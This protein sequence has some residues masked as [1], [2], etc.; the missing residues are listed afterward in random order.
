MP[1]GV[2]N[3][4]KKYLIMEFHF[5]PVQGHTDAPYRMMHSRHYGADQTYYT[6]F[7]RV[8]G[9]GI[10]RQDLKSLDHDFTDGIELIPQ[11][12]FRDAQELNILVNA[13]KEQG[14][15]RIDLNMGCPFPLQTARGRGAATI[16]NKELAL[17]VAE[18]VNNN[19]EISFSVKTRLGLND[20]DEWKQLLPVLNT[21]KLRHIT[22]HPR[23]AR[24]QYT[25][26]PNLEKFKEFLT[27]STNPVIYNGDILTPA[28]ADK[29]MSE[30]PDIKGIMIGRGALARPSIFSEI[31]SKEEWD[32]EKRLKKL[33]IFHRDLL[34]YY[35][36]NLC[37]DHQILSKIKPF[38]EYSENEIGR[39]AW[40]AI[41]KSVNMAKYHSAVAQI[42]N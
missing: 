29:I 33:L 30:F 42:S 35:S 22:L 12:I 27:S 15:K 40:K 5:A 6:P 34:N 9:D 10:R 19:P 17:G 21:L 8:E 36:G 24:Q 23:V 7:I 26:E 38:W 32:K 16:L 41:R 39:K 14:F 28:D 13:L 3:Q 11:I 31:L 37:G 1:E 2:R 18:T 4:E 20:T 25:G